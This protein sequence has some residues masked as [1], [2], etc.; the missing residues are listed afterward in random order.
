VG[1]FAVYRLNISPD[2]NRIA[3]EILVRLKVKK[4]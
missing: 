4:K 1:A 3:D 2:A